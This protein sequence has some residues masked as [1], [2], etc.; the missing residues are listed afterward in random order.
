LI[1][2]GRPCLGVRVKLVGKWYFG[3]VVRIRSDIDIEVELDNGRFVSGDPHHP[4]FRR[5]D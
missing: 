3:K 5:L 1:I 2:S 4:D